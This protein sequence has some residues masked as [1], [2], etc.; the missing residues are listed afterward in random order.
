MLGLLISLG[1]ATAAG[2]QG[3]P[4]FVVLEDTVVGSDDVSFNR[5][6]ESAAVEGETVVVGAFGA[7]VAYVFERSGNGWVEST[8]LTPP[9][10]TG[11][12]DFGISVDFDGDTIAVAGSGGFFS[13]NPTGLV[14]VFVRDGEVWA[15]QATLLPPDGGG[16]SGIALDQNRLIVATD[17][18]LTIFERDGGEWD[19]GTLLLDVLPD[20]SHDVLR[21][22]SLD[23]DV[24]AISGLRD[25]QRF[26]T[27]FTYGDGVW[28]QSQELSLTFDGDGFDIFENFMELDSG[29]LAIASNHQVEIFERGD[30]G[31]FGV[32]QR[33]EVP[34]ISLARIALSDGVLAVGSDGVGQV[35]VDV[36][37]S[38][39][40]QATVVAPERES[41][42]L[43]V[44]ALS[45]DVLVLGYSGGFAEPGS[46]D[47]FALNRTTESCNDLEVTV[48]LALGDVPT[49]GDDVILGTA[50]SDVIDA[51]AG[52]DVVCGG[53]GDDV[54][55][56]GAGKDVIFGGAGDDRINAGQGVDTV[57]AGDGDDV[58]AGGR[59]KDTI[60]G[61]AGE[62]V[63]RGNKGDDTLSG[64]VGADLLRGGRDNDVLNGNAGQDVLRGERGVDA[65]DGGR[66]LDVYDGG[67][68]ADACVADA[69]GLVES[70]VSCAL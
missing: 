40:E 31:L 50:G 10:G 18:G 38:W 44:P 70:V 26:V 55:S 27:I 7:D 21:S 34:G 5:F 36:A 60:D 65:L 25:G 56:G 33:L 6:G 49:D 8:V 20:F 24:L 45:E 53:D 47:I 52:N 3:D 23:G 11:N 15:P 17:S 58:V 57:D 41:F 19:D 46:A 37:G 30:D 42:S 22:F 4:G 35:Y 69:Q 61:G 68:G 62:D 39:V 51:G 13:P 12:I 66:G 67:L 2:A 43:V 64:G 16:L 32:S 63:L 1:L 9:E 48:N 59:G 28:E 29:S 54:I 14:Q